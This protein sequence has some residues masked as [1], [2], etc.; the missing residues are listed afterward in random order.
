MGQH[1]GFWLRLIAA[2]I[3][4]IILGIAN[5]I[6][7]LVFGN[8]GITLIITVLIG[9]GYFAYQEASIKQ[10]TI[11]KNILNLKVTDTNGERISFKKATVRH[12]SKYISAFILCIG[13][14]MVAFTERKQGLHDF[15]AGTLSR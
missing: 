4:G 3:D 10:S 1:A 8:G 15:M 9:W 6:V 11:G 5:W 2:I 12:F 7:G 14:L 13:Y